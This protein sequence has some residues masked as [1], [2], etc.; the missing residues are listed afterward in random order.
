MQ[1]GRIAVKQTAQFSG[2]SCAV[3]ARYALYCA[4]VSAVLIHFSNS[5]AQI[6]SILCD[7]ETPA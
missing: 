3:P 2:Q 7:P 6:P 1:L 4:A 5:D